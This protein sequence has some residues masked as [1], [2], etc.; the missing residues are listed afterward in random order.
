M[1]GLLKKIGHGAIKM[2][3]FIRENGTNSTQYN[4]DEL[5]D[6]IIELSRLYQ[7]AENGNSLETLSDLVENELTTMDKAIEEAAIRIEVSSKQLV[8]E[9]ITSVL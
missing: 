7:S 9:Y 3:E 1:I 8:I 6:M 5:Y 2:L 4:A